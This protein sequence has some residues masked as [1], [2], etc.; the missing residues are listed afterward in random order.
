MLLTQETSWVFL[1]TPQITFFKYRFFENQTISILQILQILLCHKDT[2]AL[3]E[4]LQKDKE[5][6]VT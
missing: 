6:G 3:S 5:I 1:H 4:I 2:K